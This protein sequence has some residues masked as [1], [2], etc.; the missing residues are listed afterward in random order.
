[1]KPLIILSSF[2]IFFFTSCEKEDFKTIG[3]IKDIEGNSYETVIIGD[4]IWMAE[5]LRTTTY[6]DGTPI[7]YVQDWNLKK[8]QYC[9]YDHDEGN[10]KPYGALYNWYAV[11]TGKLAPEGWRIPTY[12]DW[13]ELKEILGGKLITGG[14]M[15]K[16][17]DGIWEEPNKL[18]NPDCGFNAYP[19]GGVLSGQFYDFKNIVYLWTANQDET[20][21]ALFYSLEN[22][23]TALSGT[24]AHKTYFLSV[25]C[26]KEKKFS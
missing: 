2:L 16:R 22:N 7:E 3:S 10:K 6:N 18:F 8:G 17:G 1:M 25:R 20:E 12:K 23:S 11:N 9:W 15:K 14:K 19:G 26:I 5:N 13:E 4:Q 24:N 21:F